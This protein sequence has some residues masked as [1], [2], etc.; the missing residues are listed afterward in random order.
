MVPLL[1]YQRQ[2]PESLSSAYRFKSFNSNHTISS[3]NLAIR[4]RSK[5]NSKQLMVKNEEG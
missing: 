3:Y 1:S 4:Q 2:K 5:L